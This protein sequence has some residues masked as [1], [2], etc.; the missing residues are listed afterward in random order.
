LPFAAVNK[1]AV[2]NRPF[3]DFGQK[4]AA[5]RK[6]GFRAGSV[7]S[8][9]LEKGSIGHIYK[10]Y[11]ARS[12]LPPIKRRHTKAPR[13]YLPAKT[14]PR[15]IGGWRLFRKTTFK[16]FP[17]TFKNVRPGTEA[18]LSTFFSLGNE[19]K[20]RTMKKKFFFNFFSA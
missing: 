10:N 17:A 9:N 13:L 15:N 4:D 1:I 16:P 2:L 6:H 5:S 3:P 11:N 14:A 8:F 20:G 18:T 12:G 7:L 19:P